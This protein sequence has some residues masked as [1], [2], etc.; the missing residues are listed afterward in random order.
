MCLE[1]VDISTWNF[2]NFWKSILILTSLFY[3]L[4]CKRMN[5]LDTFVWSICQNS[6][7]K[8]ILLWMELNTIKWISMRFEGCYKIFIMI[9]CRCCKERPEIFELTVA[10]KFI[11]SNSVVMVE[12]EQTCSLCHSIFLWSCQRLEH[13]SIRNNVKRKDCPVISVNSSNDWRVVARSEIRKQLEAKACSPNWKIVWI[14]ILL[15][16]II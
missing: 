14:F 11:D 5:N 4:V 1:I 10:F 3:K 9:S 16:S 13:I 7:F 6:P 15:N 12:V 2:L 8:R